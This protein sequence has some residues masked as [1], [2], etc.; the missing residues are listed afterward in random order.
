MLEIFNLFKRL[1]MDTPHTSLQLGFDQEAIVM[2][3][4]QPGRQWRVSFSGSY[5]NARCSQEAPLQPGDVV[6]VVDRQNITLIIEPKL[7]NIAHPALNVKVE[8]KPFLVSLFSV[9]LPFSWLH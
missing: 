2:E 7:A 1:F 8:L 9:F 4:I 6:Y 5:W 3:V